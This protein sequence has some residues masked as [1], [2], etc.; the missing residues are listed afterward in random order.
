MNQSFNDLAEKRSILVHHLTCTENYFKS[1]D[2]SA[3]FTILFSD[4]LFSLVLFLS[5]FVRFFLELFQNR[6][7]YFDFA[8]NLMIDTGLIILSCIKGIC[9]LISAI[10]SFFLPLRCKSDPILFEIEKCSEDVHLQYVKC[11]E[12]IEQVLLQIENYYQLIG[13]Y[14]DFFYQELGDLNTKAVSSQN[15]FFSKESPIILAKQR[16][17]QLFSAYPIRE[18]FTR[19]D[20]IE[21][22]TKVLDILNKYK[23]ELARHHIIVI[24]KADIYLQELE[25][26]KSKVESKLSD[27][28]Q[29][30]VK[31]PPVL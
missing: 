16:F 15:T 3:D 5:N 12:E 2:S 23:D 25:Y 9:V 29:P 19:K 11:S 8:Q 22:K 6:S 27:F 26:F 14:H 17:Y 31:I 7:V 30:K 1:F 20:L 28:E 10:Y 24:D 4:F 18:S 21:N 13:Y